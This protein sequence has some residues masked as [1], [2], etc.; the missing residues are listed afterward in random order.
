MMDHNGTVH[1]Q[2]FVVGHEQQ[3][4]Y[5]TYV[6]MHKFG[7][8]SWQVGPLSTQIH[9]YICFIDGYDATERAFYPRRFAASPRPQ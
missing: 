7:L 8:H 2:Q 3:V 5:V 9:F 6:G 1:V 4:S